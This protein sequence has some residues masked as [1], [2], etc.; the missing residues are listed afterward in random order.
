MEWDMLKESK[1]LFPH[2]L[3]KSENSNFSKH[4]SI[5]NKQQLDLRHKLKTIDWSRLLNK[6]IQIHKVQNEPHKWKIEFEVNVPRL[7]EVNIYKNPTIVDNNVVNTLD[8]IN[9]YF[10]ESKFYKYKNTEV[11]N[12]SVD[13]SIDSEINVSKGYTDEIKGKENEY[14]YD[15]NSES[16]YIFENDEFKTYD[17]EL[18]NSSLIYSESFID[19]YSHFFRYIHYEN[20]ENNTIIY[21]NVVDDENNQKYKTFFDYSDVSNTGKYEL[22]VTDNEE[23]PI[24]YYNIIT[25]KYCIKEDDKFVEVDENDYQIITYPNN[26]KVSRIPLIESKDITPIISND[27]Y[28]IEV[29]TWN[30]YHFLKGFPDDYVNSNQN[31]IIDPNEQTYNDINIDIENINDTDYLTFRIHQYGLKLVEIFKNNKPIHV[32]DFIVEKLGYSTK[33]LSSDFAHVYNYNDNE[34]YYPFKKDS[35]S[36]EE[37]KLDVNEYVWRLKLTDDDKIFDENGKWHYELKDKY[38]IEVTYYN[39]L[40]PYDSEYD[41]KLKKTYVYEDSIF[42]HDMSLD[43]IGKLFNVP[44]HIFRQPQLETETETEKFYSETYPPYCDTYSEDDYHYQKRLQYYINNYNKIYF[45]CLELWKYFNITSELVNR[46]VIVAEQNYSYMRTLDVE[47]KKYINELGKNKVESFYLDDNYI[48]DE[49]EQNYDR[50]KLRS[51]IPPEDYLNSRNG[52]LIDENGENIRDIHG[53]L[54]RTDYDYSIIENNDGEKE[55]VIALENALRKIQWYNS[56]YDNDSYQIKLTKSLKVVPNTKYQLRFCVKN[57]PLSGLDLKLIYKN[58]NGDIR[59]VESYTPEREDYDDEH[60][61]NELIYTNYHEE[62]GVSCE[63][64]C[65]DFTTLNTAQNIEIILESESQFKIS[66]VTLQRITVNHY[67]SEYMKTNNDYNSCVYDLYADYTKIPSNIRYENLNIF[68]KV[69]NRSLPLTKKGYFNFAITDSNSGDDLY[70]STEANIYFENLLTVE[71]SVLPVNDYANVNTI[72]ENTG[73]YEHSYNFNK[74]INSG[75]Y[76]IYL[77]AYQQ[78]ETNIINNFKIDIEMLVFN[79]NNTA[80]YKT[81]TIHNVK[82]YKKV[83]KYGIYFEIPFMNKSDNSMRITI[84]RSSPFAFK[85]FKLIREEPLNMEEMI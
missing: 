46:K 78:I 7:K 37:I 28:V 22:H 13:V 32:V 58:N 12:L 27:R 51:I 19:N 9:G 52:I 8:V 44:R 2:W 20:N 84:S 48:T 67:D 23:E 73:R 72:N 45:P 70:L 26:S 66:D 42:Y 10:N 18:P 25:K 83:D 17:G 14:Y 33:T 62:F 63:Y 49:E 35:D 11:T 60:E 57:Y 55:Y 41:K 36:L 85:D 29:I 40:H 74:Y 61:F 31:N 15:L 16:Y 82:D 80:S 43:M 6:P 79:K 30:D 3:D 21:E 38:D 5:I 68:N 81:L 56:K 65:T 39:S 69:L 4:L 64:I 76:T 59:E 77:K 53:L 50:P 1:K 24:L 47:Q 54:V 71:S 75:K 34:L